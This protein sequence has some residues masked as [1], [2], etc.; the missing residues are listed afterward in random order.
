M[1]NVEWLVHT[2]LILKADNEPALRILV[3][4]SMEEIRIK[5]RG[6][7]QISTEHPPRYDSQWR[8][9]YGSS[10]ASSAR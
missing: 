6:V 5:V 10:D 7:A 2:R 1:K 8:P 3:E 9:A 4:Q